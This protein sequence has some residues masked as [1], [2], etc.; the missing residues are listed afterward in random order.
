MSLKAL[1]FDVDGTLAET[2]E[3]HRQSF[4]DTFAAHGLDWQ[5]DEALYGDLLQTAGSRARLAVWM[6]DHLGRAPDPGLIAALYRTKTARY[7]RLLA[8]GGVQLRP[9][10]ADLIDDAARAGLT[11]A[12]ATSAGRVNVVALCDAVF[13]RP[14]FQVFDVIAA[15]DE[16]AA[17]KPAPDVYRLAL[18]RLGL[19]PADCVAL[20][21]SHIGVR[22]ARAAGLAVLA[23]PSHY[24]RHEDLSDATQCVNTYTEIGGAADLAARLSTVA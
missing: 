7:G 17:N 19:P 16:V 3:L 21:D 10:I 18:K 15:G 11:L 2:E 24:T 1:I 4:N 22:A 23:C 8:G 5:W 20:E 12:V 14:A 6:R 13:G 9:G